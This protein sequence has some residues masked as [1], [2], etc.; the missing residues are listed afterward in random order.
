M[1]ENPIIDEIHRIRE[2]ILAEYGGDLSA[3]IRDSE[4]K[5][6]ELRKAGRLVVTRSPRPVQQPQRSPR[7][8][9]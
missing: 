6:E 8:V 7:K 3:L 5:T 9:G 2:E 1:I 4:R